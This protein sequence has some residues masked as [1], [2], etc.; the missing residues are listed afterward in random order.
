MPIKARNALTITNMCQCFGIANFAL[1][2]SSI[3]SKQISIAD[4]LVGFLCFT[5]TPLLISGMFSNHNYSAKALPVLIVA[6][7]LGVTPASLTITNVMSG[8]PG[9]LFPNGLHSGLTNDPHFLLSSLFSL[10]AI[11]VASVTILA[12]N[13]KQ[14]GLHYAVFF[15]SFSLTDYLFFCLLNQAYLY[16]LWYQY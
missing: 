4:V 13:A 14:G 1:C 3:S 7:P 16:F 9:I 12:S 11:Q 10:L 5:M 15:S 8:T 6:V 2:A